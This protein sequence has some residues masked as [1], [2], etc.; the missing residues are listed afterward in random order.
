MP[1]WKQNADT[2][3]S[4]LLGTAIAENKSVSDRTLQHRSKPRSAASVI[5]GDQHLYFVSSRI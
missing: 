4:P 1:L 2:V 5:D 3:D